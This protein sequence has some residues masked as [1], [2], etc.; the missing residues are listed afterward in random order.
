V[1]VLRLLLLVL[2]RVA[3]TN[4][5]NMCKPTEKRFITLSELKSHNA[6]GSAWTVVDDQV[7]DISQFSKRHPGGDIILLSAGKDASVLFRTYHP[8]G[9][10]KALLNK[11]EIGIMKD[12]SKSYY[13]WSSE[14]YPTLRARVTERL[15]ALNRPLRGNADIQIK[16]VFILTIFWCVMLCECTEVAINNLLS[17]SALVTEKANDNLVTVTTNLT[18][19]VFPYSIYFSFDRAS[20][21]KMYT[22]DFP[23]AII[24][25]VVMG[26]FAHLVGTCIQHDG[27]HGAFSKS[28]FINTLAVSRSSPPRFLFVL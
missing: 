26:F 24:Y 14:F 16:A 10:P 9:V 8:R 7:I 25:S 5:S 19:F 17:S 21:F 15:A 12:V 20:L 13:D 4:S 1:Q 11:L 22:S 18:N 23:Q 2:L 3:T 27:N 28:P 6:P